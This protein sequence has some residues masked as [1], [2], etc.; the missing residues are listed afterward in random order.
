M[1][2]FEPRFDVLVV[3]QVTLMLIY[4][5]VS[6]WKNVYAH[7]NT[8]AEHGT[9]KVVTFSCCCLSPQLSIPMPFLKMTG[10]KM[11]FYCHFPDLK[12]SGK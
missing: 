7:V 5:P 11:V 8:L 2:L 4:A 1:L 12:L 9:S 3:D 10:S 6:R